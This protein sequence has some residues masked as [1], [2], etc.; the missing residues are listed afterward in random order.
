MLL[1]QIQHL[2]DTYK[3]SGKVY[4]ASMNMRGKW[5]DPPSDLENYIKVNVTSAQNKSN[6]NRRDFSPMT[7]IE[8]GYKGYW[9]FESYWQSGKVFEDISIETT[10]KWWKALKG[11]QNQKGKRFML[12]NI[13]NLS[14]REK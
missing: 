1:L 4:I 14:K 3:M 11:F 13:I 10:K 2:V 8:D 5:A 12:L 9:N 7:A 6:K